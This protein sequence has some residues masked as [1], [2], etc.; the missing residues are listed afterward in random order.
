MPGH[1]T[2]P[3]D[4]TGSEV[5][6]GIPFLKSYAVFNADQIDGLPDRFIP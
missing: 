3:N 1:S 6:R 4:T 2:G 5:A